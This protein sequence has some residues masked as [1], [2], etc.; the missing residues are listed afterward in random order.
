[1]ANSH[2]DLSNRYHTPGG[3]FVQVSG[4]ETVCSL[5]LLYMCLFHKDFIKLNGNT[6]NS[7]ICDLNMIQRIWLLLE[8]L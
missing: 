4:A 3:Y 5:T 7:Y 8:R 6:F 2:A 1:V